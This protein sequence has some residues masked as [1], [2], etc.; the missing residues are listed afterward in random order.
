MLGHFSLAPKTW[1]PTMEQNFSETVFLTFHLRQ[2]FPS[3]TIEP[4]MTEPCP[5]WHLPSGTPLS[6]YLF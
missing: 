6:F 5:L 2:S 1:S 4:Q 3:V